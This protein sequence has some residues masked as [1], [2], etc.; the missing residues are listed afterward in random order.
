MGTIWIGSELHSVSEMMVGSH[1]LINFT[2]D[3]RSGLV[4]IGRPEGGQDSKTGQREASSVVT[5]AI[6][7][8][9]LCG[10]STAVHWVLCSSRCVGSTH[11]TYCCALG[12]DAV[13]SGTG[14]PTF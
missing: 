7:G 11:V 4:D 13:Q 3:D 9:S 8:T 14:A 12:Y 6:L 5:L 2:D 1:Q 10:L